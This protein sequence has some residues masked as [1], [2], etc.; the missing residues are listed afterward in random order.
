MRNYKEIFEYKDGIGIL[1]YKKYWW[2]K[3]KYCFD[4]ETQGL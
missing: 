1:K 3:W 2:S 4:F